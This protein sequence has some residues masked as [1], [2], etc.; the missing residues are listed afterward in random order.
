LDRAKLRAKLADAG[1]QPGLPDGIHICIPK[2]TIWVYFWYRKF[3]YI[4]W[5]FRIFMN[6]L[7]FLS[8]CCVF[9]YFVAIGYVF[10]KWV[11]NFVIW[12]VCLYVFPHFGMCTKKDLATLHATLLRS[13]NHPVFKQTLR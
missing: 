10:S 6:H 13:L 1:M 11:Y 2:I 3:G 9:L 12:Y 4:L 7:V 5:P 8:P